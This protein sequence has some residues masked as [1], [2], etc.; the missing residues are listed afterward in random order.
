MQVPLVLFDPNV[1]LVSWNSPLRLS[2]SVLARLEVVRAAGLQRRLAVAEGI[3][4]DR[5]ARRQVAERPDLLELP[6]V[7]V[8]PR[9]RGVLAL[10]RQEVRP[11]HVLGDAAAVV[12]RVLPVVA[13][14]AV[15]APLAAR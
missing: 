6:G 10:G 14:P 8:D 13:Q 5:H 4:G 15:D 7:R 2:A 9:L 12:L 11:D 3:V 1:S